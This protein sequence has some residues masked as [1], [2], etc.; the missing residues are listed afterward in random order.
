LVEG[1]RS[2]VIECVATDH[3]PHSREEKE[4][5][6]EQAPMGVI[7]LETAF[8]ALYTELVLPGHLELGK[9]VDRMTAGAEVIGL[10]A[11]TIRPGTAADLCLADLEA[12]WEVGEAGFES[13]SANSCFA[14]RRLRG[15]IRMT[16]AG[17]AVAYRERS[18]AIGVV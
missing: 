9:L 8:A 7:G 3:A 17:G 13:R 18:F 5:P 4:Q 16:I 12:E 2:G 11:P 10:P 6:F 1:L 15:R 14:G